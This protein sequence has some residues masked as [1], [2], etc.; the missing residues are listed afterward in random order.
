MEL[1]DEFTVELPVER[2]F[3]LLSDVERIAPCLPGAELQE[4]DGEEYRGTVK[5]KVG[6]I[7]AQY[8]GV[9]RFLEQDAGAHRMVLRAEGRETRGRATPA[10]RSPPS[11]IR[12]ATTALAYA[13]RRTS[14]SRARWRSSGAACW[15]R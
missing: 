7:T 14:R 2:A 15:R 5:V 12:P 1:N 8:K 11:S 10:P 9:A 3:A 13:S 6:P 4:V